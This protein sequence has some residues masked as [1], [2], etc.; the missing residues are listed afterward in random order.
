[1]PSLALVQ[2]IVALHNLLFSP[3]KL[4]CSVFNSKP[5]PGLLSEVESSKAMYL[6][7]IFELLGIPI[8]T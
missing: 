6:N 2:V 5:L 1:M 7:S 8:C 4:E 3:N